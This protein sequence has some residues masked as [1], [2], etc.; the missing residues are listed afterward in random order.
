[1]ALEIFFDE[2]SKYLDNIAIIP[3]DVIITGDL[4]FHVDIR[5]YVEACT[6]FSMLDSYGLT[7]HVNRVTHKGG[8]T[9]FGH[10]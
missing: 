3:Y 5:Y 6:F 7:Q 4:N 8:H 1:M 2:W 10:I 9:I